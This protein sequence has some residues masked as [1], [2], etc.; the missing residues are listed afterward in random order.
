MD[1]KNNT[2]VSIKRYFETFDSFDL[3]SKFGALNLEFE[4]QNKNLLTSYATTVGLFN[5]NSGKP[6]IS[7]KTMKTLID[8]LNSSPIMPSIQDPSESAFYEDIYLDKEYKVFNGINTSSAFYV[9]AIIGMLFY[10]K[11]GLD[12]A[13]K[14][15]VI[16][17]IKFALFL[18]DSVFQKSYIK[19]SVDKDHK[20]IEKLLFS[21]R[22][23]TYQKA[24]IF[25][26]NVINGYITKDELNEYFLCST[27]GR[28]ME[29]CL[30]DEFPFYY[31]SPL[32]E[33]NGKLLVLDPTSIC[34]FIKNL[35]LRLSKEFNCEELFL[36][37]YYD[38]TF[39]Y[40]LEQCKM[41]S[42]IFPNNES[43]IIEELNERFRYYAYSI[44]NKVVLFVCCRIDSQKTNPLGANFDDVFKK[45]FSAIKKK[46][47]DD[48]NTYTLVTFN[49]Y[50]GQAFFNS[51]FK[52]KNQ[53]VMLA[54]PD[55]EMVQINEKNN[56]FFLE[57]FTL[58]L[59][60]YFPN[61]K[62]SMVFS[63]VNLI[64]MI[65]LKGYDYYLG[66]EINT[67][68][69]SFMLN[70]AF[71][72][73]Y[74]YC[75]KALK[76]KQNSVALFDGVDNPV[77]LIKY[78]DNIY[79][80]NPIICPLFNLTP[81]YARVG[82]YGFWIVSKREDETGL[83]V[84]RS[85][86][87]WLNQISNNITGLI[88]HNYYI[89]VAQVEGTM[90]LFLFDEKRCELRYTRKY[91]EEF[92]NDDNDNEI[93]MVC[94]ILNIFN[95]LNPSIIK[96][97]KQVSLVKFRK[98]IYTINAE[99]DPF[100]RPLTE[101]LPPLRCSKIYSSMMDDYCGDYISNE[102][103]IPFGEIKNPAFV[104]NS[105]VDYLFDV[106]KRFI[107]KFNWLN[108]LERCYLYSEKM[109]TELLL[110]QDNLKHQFALYPEHATDI[111]KNNDEINVSSISVR[112]IVEYLAAIKTSGDLIISDDDIQYAMGIV[113]SI[114]R[115]A[116]I[117][118]SYRYSL[119]D[120]FNFLESGRIG[121]NHERIERFN[122]LLS[123]AAFNDSIRRIES[124]N[125]EPSVFPFEE[126]IK[127]AY[128]HEHGFAT[129]QMALAIAVIFACGEEQDSEIKK[130]TIDDLLVMLHRNHDI[131]MDDE[132]FARIIDFLTIDY[133]GAF[134]DNSIK[135]RE[136]HP[137][138]YNR[139]WSL[140]RKPLV[141]R[142]G[143]FY[144]GNRML[145]HSYLFIMQTIRSGKEPSH[146]NTKDGIG[147]L[148]GKI[149]EHIGEEFNDYCFN[150]LKSNMPKL[151]FDKCV[152]SI[153]NKRI[154]IVDH[155]PL[156]DIDILAIDKDKKRIYLIETKRFYY[157]RNPSELDNEIT[158]MFLGTKKKKS[159]LEK[160]LL[161]KQWVENHVNDVIAQYK[162]SGNGWKVRYTFLTYKPLLS[163]EFVSMSINHIDLKSITLNY[164]RK[165]K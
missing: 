29:K 71:D 109:L 42:G 52:F 9:N 104:I 163:S 81:L 53:P 89:Q 59:N 39:D 131:N 159:F 1:N 103:Q 73:I 75:V 165:L 113:E 117:S 99:R 34:Y 78:E 154:Q 119:V 125:Y 79:F 97:L 157:S 26:S 4:N 150:Y 152:K 145:Y 58:F 149:L 92:N 33:F 126:E 153:N 54:V 62:L 57:N 68:N 122:E 21:N 127:R 14:T 66:D 82:E 41:L 7:S 142:D 151:V 102:L 124:F 60:Y 83:L 27:K 55:L 114:I 67:R 112:F 46:G 123:S 130:G 45:A 63:I 115:W 15:K 160:E 61:D 23:E 93:S 144:W 161:R 43:T 50:G 3:I 51:G 147:C 2:L 74:P 70:M 5:L 100:L 84:A 128:L 37:N 96:K 136:L 24:L 110:Y 85:L 30:N 88:N 10:R 25:D 40:S 133:R 155:E 17:L 18:S 105:T 95:I 139:E 31:D 13:F 64:G 98:I 111:E 162:L 158:D 141:K 49:S 138:K 28:K 108:A 107:D 72:F 129:E 90:S 35:C 56:P 106:F 38:S 47:F 132:T 76:E 44:G 135:S 20:Y 77:R 32:L 148:N 87:Y 118:D 156:G 12:K 121:Y 48:K 86:G 94:N 101:K 22:L 91:L 80:P 16:R 143:S 146:D 8:L 134:Y 19:Q 140:M 120:S 6:K 164:L 116:K 11:T 65:H 69:K 137:W 36:K